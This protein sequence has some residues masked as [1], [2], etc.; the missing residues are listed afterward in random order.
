MKHFTSVII[1]VL[2]AS[3]YTVAQDTKIRF[4]GHPGFEYLYNNDLKKGSPYFRSGPFV[5]FVTSQ[6]NDKV[7]V[8]GE[9]HAHYMATTGAE[10][11][12]ERLYIT[13]DHKDYLSFRF[14]KMY[15][16]IGYWNLN[17]NFGLVLQ[18]TISRPSI[19]Q[20]THD[21]GFINTRDAGFQVEGS[22]ISSVGFFYKAFVFNGVG[23]NGGYLGIPYQLG[24]A[25]GAV[26]QLGLEPTDGLKISASGMYQILQKGYPNQYDSVFTEDIKSMMWAGSV[27]FMN[28]DKKFEC[29]TEVFYDSK[30]YKSIGTKGLYGGFIYLGYKLSSK[31]IPYIYSET[32]KFDYTDIYYPRINVYTGQPYVDLTKFDLG[33]RYK[34]SGSLVYKFELEAMKQDRFGF[35]FGAKTQVAFVF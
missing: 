21:G 31:I 34:Y 33:L 26:L 11:E 15:T 17:Y 23:K 25:P 19:L 24:E 30:Q 2:L 6:L 3:Y 32:T 18:P 12:I 8:A 16:P 4:F 7:A 10:V 20:P 27:S 29:I 1:F 14:G 5:L 22:G 13:Y 28:P 35:S 9:V